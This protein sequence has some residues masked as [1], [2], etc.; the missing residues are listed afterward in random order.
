MSPSILPQSIKGA[1]AS[2][3]HACPQVAWRRQWWWVLLCFNISPQF[4][5]SH[6]TFS[7]HGYLVGGSSCP[8]SVN[9]GNNRPPPQSLPHE[10]HGEGSDHKF[11]SFFPTIPK[12]FHSI[13]CSY[14]IIQLAVLAALPQSIK[15]TTACHHHLLPWGVLRIRWVFLLFPPLFLMFL[16]DFFSVFIFHS[17]PSSQVYHAYVPI[18]IFLSKLALVLWK[19]L[20]LAILLSTAVILVEYYWLL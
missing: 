17:P 7:I 20:T 5:F 3:H 19:L 15:G 6:S 8:P 18:K 14:I 9:Q 2:C 12:L 13:F 4:I 16:I 11:S 10:L 1:R